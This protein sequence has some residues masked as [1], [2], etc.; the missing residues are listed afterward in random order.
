MFPKI[1]EIERQDGYRLEV[2]FDT[3]EKGVVDLSDLPGEGGV[4][5]SLS[6]PEYFRKVYLHS[7]LGVLTWPQWRGHRPGNHIQP[8]DREAAP[9]VG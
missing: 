2:V 7:E 4:F 1:M 3:G 8:G 6:D 5:S 9:G